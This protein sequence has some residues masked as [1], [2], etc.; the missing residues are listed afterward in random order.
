MTLDRE[1][2][3]TSSQRSSDN[4]VSIIEYELAFRFDLQLLSVTLELPGV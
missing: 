3:T 2:N 4:H 1:R